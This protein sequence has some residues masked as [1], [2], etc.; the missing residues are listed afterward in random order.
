MREF[1]T[2]RDYI[3][4]KLIIVAKLLLIL[5]F[6]VF[7]A[8]L[9]VLPF[10]NHPCADD[11]ICGYHLR[12]QGFLGYQTFIYNNWGGR[13]SAT[14]TGALFAA[15]GFL[16]DHY[17]LHS[18]LLFVLNVASVFFTFFLIN[19]HVLKDEKL[20]KNIVWICLLYMC[21]QLM[22]VVEVSTYQFWFSSAVTYQLPIILLQVEAGLWI[23]L[24]HSK[25]GFGK[26]AAAVVMPLL[27]FVINGFNELFIIVQTFMLLLPMLSKAYKRLST[28]LLLSVIVAFILSAFVVLLSPGIHERTAIIE[29]KGILVGGV[30]IGY[31]LAEVLWSIFSKPL[32]WVILLITFLYANTRKDQFQELLFARFFK[33]RRWLLPLMLLLFF[34]TMIAVAVVGLKGG[35]IPDRY[36]NGVIVIMVSGLLLMVFSEGIFAK[37]IAFNLFAKETRLVLLFVYAV[38]ILSNNYIKDAYKSV[39]A[40]PLYSNIMKIR[41]QTLQ[42]AAVK[43]TPA[44]LRTYDAQMKTILQKDYAGST[45]TLYDLVQQK[46]LFI[47]FEDDLDTEYSV[48][49]LKAYYGVDSVLLKRD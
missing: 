25:N 16:Y 10:F 11:Y 14:F 45:K 27:V 30:A 9:F 17:Y 44:I 35:V 20:H 46:P 43:G 33:G 47:F 5:A 26:L 34:V 19:K 40:A 13:F 38:C 6:V 39:V 22:S 41:A 48:N 21:L 32:L 15:D 37:R 12:E 29:P 4:S 31:H 18:L 24:L 49:T 7:F 8:P 23:I 28:V 1:F 2:D 36:V 3:I 42:Q